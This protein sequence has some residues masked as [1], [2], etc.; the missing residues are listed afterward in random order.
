MLQQY[1]RVKALH[2]DEIL[3]FRMGD[4]YE[5]F[6]SDAE[7]VSRELG[8][9]LT[10]R[11]KGTSNAAPMAGV[12][13]KA[14]DTYLQRLV[15]K[16]YKV[17]ICEQLEDAAEAEGLVDRGVVRIVTPGTLTEDATLPGK[18]NNFLMAIVPGKKQIGLSWMDI[19]TGHFLVHETTQELLGDEVAR[20]APAECLLPETAK[21]FPIV[22]GD[23]TLTLERLVQMQQIALTA[24]P[25]W[26]FDSD[27]GRRTLLEHFKIASLEAYGCEEMKEGLGAAGALIHYLEETQKTSLSCL[28]RLEK[29]KAGETMLLDRATRT[30]LELTSAMRGRAQQGTLSSV[31][32]ETCTAM[33]AR[34]LHNWLTAPLTVAAPIVERYDALEE[35][36]SRPQTIQKMRQ[37]L[38]QI[39]DMER[40]C[41]RIAYERANAR[42]LLALCKSLTAVPGIASLIGE[43]TSPLLARMKTRLSVL[44]DL[45]DLLTRAI[46]P[47]PR[48]TLK[49]GGIIK[50]GYSAELDELRVLETSADE[51]IKKFEAREIERSKIPSLK[52]GYNKVF[53]FYI[54]VT[55]T[56]GHKVPGDYVRKQTLKNAER[57]ITHELK[58]YEGKALSATERAKALEYELFR[59]VVQEVVQYLPELRQTAEAIGYIDV[60]CALAKVARDH[61]YIRP[62]LTGTNDI[63]IVAGRHPVL[64][65]TL[66]RPFVPNDTSMG[67]GREIIIITGPNMAGKSTYIRQAAL[68]VLMAQMGSFIPAQQASIGIVDRIFTRI[69][70]ADEIARGRSTFLVEMLE[71]A[72]IL[73]NATDRS[74]IVLDEVGRGTSTFDG[75]S[76]AWAIVEYIQQKIGART[77]FATHYHEIAELSE[78][79][80][81]IHNYSVAVQ[82]W[83]DEITFLYKI[84]A[85]SADKSY[86]IQVAK[87][88]GIPKQVIQRSQEILKNLEK[89][90]VDFQTYT[91]RCCNKEKTAGGHNLFSLVGEEIIDTLA[92]LDLTRLSP[93]EAFA[94][95]KE[96]HEEARKM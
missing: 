94:L 58:E 93:L 37:E 54:E 62:V 81:N 41:A 8:L 88:S 63:A 83:K 68:L 76:L 61:G 87:L 20:I 96:L 29:Y 74:F 28:A 91:R 12:P 90:A 24:R 77:L 52:V 86:G 73:N 18:N 6:F 70:A 31:L 95:L 48:H 4:F 55:H 35:F 19:S 92:K 22:S 65:V 15:Q 69:G 47:E 78:V 49:D 2:Q 21:D 56:H 9:T 75:I 53:G 59:S 27:N 3:F 39:Q 80:P 36:V 45:S 16:G 25:P 72:N 60:L 44:H 66:E 84:V 57:Y 1:N 30:C 64:D 51:W 7:L 38:S 10:A 32:D 23:G 82:E 50:E 85:G 5:M 46:H 67:A 17:A 11:N 26:F 14:L 13:A 71:T 42:D 40:L 89:H 34:L 79:Y 33:G 43:C